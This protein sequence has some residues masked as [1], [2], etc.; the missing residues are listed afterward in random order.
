[1]LKGTSSSSRDGKRNKTVDLHARNSKSVC[2][3]DIGPFGHP[4]PRP[5]RAVEL[6][7]CLQRVSATV[8][9]VGHVF[10]HMAPE[11]CH[12]QN[13]FLL[14][15]CIGILMLVLTGQGSKAQLASYGIRPKM[16]H[17]GEGG[18][19]GGGGGGA[20]ETLLTCR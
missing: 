10:F 9:G 14:Q 1:M 2:T 17:G 15:A 20:G 18:G 7:K 19:G 12:A 8:S 6:S 13:A 4:S 16:R 11:I 3:N 5:R